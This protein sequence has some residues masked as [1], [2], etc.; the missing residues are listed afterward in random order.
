MKCFY[1]NDADGRCAAYWVKTS[2]MGASD[3]PCDYIEMT[4]AKKFPMDVISKNELVYIVDFSISPVEM[5]GLLEITE[6]VVWID[7]HK[8]AIEKYAGFQPEIPG[9]RYNGIAGCMLTYIYLNIMSFGG[10]DFCN[11][12][13]PE[14]AEH[15]PMFTKLIADWDVWKFRYG[16]DTRAFI[17]AFNAYDFHPCSHNWDNI[18]MGGV[19]DMCLEGKSML[20]YR[21]GWAKDYTSLGFETEFE[22]HLCFAMNIGHVNSEYFKSLPEGKYDIF[23]PFVFNGEQYTCS[24]YST[25]V[26]VSEIA[27]KYG[28]GGHMKA[29]GFQC[30]ELPFKKKG[31]PRT[32]TTQVIT[33]TVTN[34]IEGDVSQPD[35]HD[36]NVALAEKIKEVLDA[37][38]VTVESCKTF[39]REEHSNGT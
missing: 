1:H 18:R 8:T 24:L 12:F 5:R 22:G 3:N 37:D 39:V 19:K 30:K 9:I 29:S 11:E 6:N 35:N 38:N 14:F 13:N 2:A 26:D 16:D 33:L 17:T 15:A 23:I 10:E 28:G 31:D 25:S 20:K 21:D 34:I 36:Y 4:Y 7:H 32:V 27:K